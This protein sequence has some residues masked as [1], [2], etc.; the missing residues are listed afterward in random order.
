MSTDILGLVGAI[1]VV[2]AV[3]VAVKWWEHWI[4]RLVPFLYATVFTSA[5]FGGTAE[6]FADLLI[7]VLVVNSATGILLFFAWLE[8]RK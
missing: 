1:G 4:V 5:W 3:G 7:S 8:I 2:V 6:S